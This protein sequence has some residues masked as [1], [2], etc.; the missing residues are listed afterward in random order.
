MAEATEEM[1]DMEEVI[2]KEVDN[3]DEDNPCMLTSESFLA[4]LNLVMVMAC[5][6]LPTEELLQFE[7]AET[8]S[9]K[10]QEINT[11][12]SKLQSRK[13]ELQDF[14]VIERRPSKTQARIVDSRHG[15][16]M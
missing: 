9:A 10:E 15:R 5:L 3:K 12:V 8:I 16:K 1:Y 11:M 6:T 4:Q 2:K 13:R 7:E 14:K